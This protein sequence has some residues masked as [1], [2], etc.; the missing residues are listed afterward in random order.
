MD[1]IPWLQEN[2]ISYSLKEI[3]GGWLFTIENAL[4]S[5]GVLM[6]KPPCSYGRT[7]KTS[8]GL[9]IISY[10][11]F[12]FCKNDGGKPL[13]ISPDLLEVKTLPSDGL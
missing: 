9:F 8:V 12:F 10:E 4:A 13:F 1:F 11:G 2:G 6:I 7:A 5:D 3:E